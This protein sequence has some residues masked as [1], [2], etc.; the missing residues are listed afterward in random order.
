MIA[1]RNTDKARGA[2]GHV[3]ISN[4]GSR[5]ISATLVGY[6]I[7]QMEYS[8]FRHSVS[9]VSEDRD[10]PLNP[11]LLVLLC[12]ILSFSLWANIPP[13]KILLYFCSHVNWA[14]KGKNSSLFLQSLFL[15]ISS[16][17]LC[18]F[19]SC[20]YVYNSGSQLF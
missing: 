6:R 10:E 14:D 11:I 17:S 5:Y 20:H 16:G 13:A 12:F 9:E 15:K 3:N 18:C 1:R 4:T 2:S 19:T 8:F 7:L